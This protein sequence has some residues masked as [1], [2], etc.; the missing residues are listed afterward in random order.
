M[1]N[2]RDFIESLPLYLNVTERYNCPSCGN[3][4]TLAVTKKVGGTIW[5][6]FHNSCKTQGKVGGT[7]TAANIS[8]LL[9]PENLTFKLF[10]PNSSWFDPLQ[11]EYILNR[12]GI[13]DV[14]K[15]RRIHAGWDGEKERYVF[16]VWRND[17]C[18]GA[19]GRSYKQQPKWLI[20]GM[21][22]YKLPLVVPKYG[23]YYSPYYQKGESKIGVVVEDALSAAAVSHVFD[24]IAIL[25]THIPEHYIPILAAYDEL[26]IALDEDATDKAV[27]YQQMLNVFTPTKLVMLEKDLKDM[28]KEQIKEKLDE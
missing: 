10:S 19:I 13:M 6:C 8:E 23:T 11:V 21:K 25:G 2:I 18:A 24:G 17:I 14:Y 22:Q 7:L 15:E 20:Y 27:E 4:N 26:Y 3:Y 16:M 28:T 9:E 1:A 12:H 5:F